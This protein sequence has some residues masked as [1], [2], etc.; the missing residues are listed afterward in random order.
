MRRLFTG[1]IVVLLL[2]TAIPARAVDTDIARAEK[3][4]KGNKT[5][6]ASKLYV[7][8]TV[9]K[10]RDASLRSAVMDILA[11]PAPTF[12]ARYP[13]VAAREAVRTRLVE[14]GLLE[15]TVSVTDLFP[16]L[17]N[18]KKAVQSF[19]VAPGGTPDMHHDYPG[20]LIEH[21]AFNL[22]AALDLQ[23]N[24]QKRY[25][26]PAL[27]TD[28]VIAAPILHDAYKAWVLQWTKDGS[29]TVQ[30][31]VAGTASH[32]PFGVAE[33]IYRGLSAEMCV[34]QASAHDPPGLAEQKVVNYVRAASVLAGVDPVERGMLRRDETGKLVLA[35]PPGIEAT[36][37]H[38]S[39]HDYIIT[40]PAGREVA[41]SLERL[42]RAEPAGKDLNIET[43]RW[44]RHRIK[45]RI[46][47]MRIYAE[48]RAG[49]DDAVKKLLAKAK[50]P[51]LDPADRTATAAVSSGGSP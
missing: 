7:L 5:A 22:Q 29:L 20:G 27:D 46:P 33:S 41:A 24:Y 23:V 40:D 21:T 48:L 25:G 50:V 44:M 15:P 51:L 42:A 10:I 12:M 16:T 49:G 30:A 37:N 19:F 39:D 38:L 45:T 2:T 17:E 9:K 3:L 28:L 31:K 35:R 11:N 1:G 6:A 8:S 18:P 26:I 13:D 36:I 14:E 32:H 34:A 43:I 4:A 47:H